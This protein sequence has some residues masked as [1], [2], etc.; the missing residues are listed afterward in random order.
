[1]EQETVKNLTK[2]GLRFVGVITIFA[3]LILTTMV[4]FQVMAAATSFPQVLPPGMSVEI[5]GAFGR[6]GYW[7][8][9]GY[10][11]IVAWGWL[12]IRFARPIA[13]GIARW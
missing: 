5:E 13:R 11:T 2:V 4:L 9:I 10:S 3:G 6:M 1:M 12:L 7:A 8:V